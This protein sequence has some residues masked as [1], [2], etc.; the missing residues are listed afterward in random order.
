MLKLG[1]PLAVLTLVLM[2]T[3]P[4]DADAAFALRV[5]GRVVD[6]RLVGTEAGES[7]IIPNDLAPVAGALVTI[8][9]LGATVIANE[10][11]RQQ[12]VAT[13]TKA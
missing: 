3:A 11:G 8:P 5:D 13:L 1:F 4:L 12:T 2:A 9:A 7:L 6:G 10:D